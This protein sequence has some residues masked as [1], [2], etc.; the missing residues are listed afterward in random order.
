MPERARKRAIVVAGV[1]FIAF[2]LTVISL[3]IAALIGQSTAQ[4]D[5][6]KAHAVAQAAVDSN[7]ALRAIIVARCNQRTAYD[8]RFVESTKDDIASIRDDI[9]TYQTSIVN[10]EA[11]LK[12]P[13]FADNPALLAAEKR[14]IQI[15]KDGVVKKQRAL[16]KKQKIVAQGVIG[17]CSIYTNPPPAP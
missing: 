17:N 13:I 9:V 12:N 5:A 4:Q 3:A 7:N 15:A 2:C 6:K 16:V 8:T 10:A 1:A 14:A 11:I